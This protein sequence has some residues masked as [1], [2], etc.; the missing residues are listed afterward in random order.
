MASAQNTE[1]PG[2][3]QLQPLPTGPTA[4]SEGSARG[5]RSSP[6]RN[7]ECLVCRELYSSSRPPKVLGCRHAFCAV[8]LKLLLCAEGEGWAVTCPLCRQHTAVPGGLVCSLR[9]LET[10]AGPVVRQAPEVRLCPQGLAEPPA[11]TSAAWQPDWAGEDGQDAGSANRAAARRLAAHLLLLVLLIVLIL[12]FVYP[13]VIRW[14]LACIIALALLLSTFF[15][16]QPGGQQSCWASPRTL[17]CRGQK[18]SEV[19][20]IA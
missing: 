20:S 18:H 8:C 5:R 13:G 4:A 10:A 19:S 2:P 15:C 7:M 11:S 3:Q 16:C 14:V 17:F 9:D 12:P 6:E 1:Q